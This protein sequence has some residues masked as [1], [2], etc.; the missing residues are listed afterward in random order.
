MSKTCRF[1][2]IT[3]GIAIASLPFYWNKVLAQNSYFQRNLV[4]DIAGMAEKTDTN[5]VNPWGIATGATSPFWV[6][7]NHKGVSTLYDGN[8]VP[9]SLVVT[10][11][12]PSGGTPPAAPTGVVSNS[13][14]NFQ[15]S[16]GLASRF[17]FATEDGTI[18]GWNS[19]ANGVVKVDNSPS[20]AVYKGLGIGATG[21]SNYLYAA[22][23][24]A[25]TI[26]VF[27]QNYGAATLAGSFLDP[28]LPAGFAP[29]NVQNIGGQ[30]YVTYA[31]Q[32]AAKHDDVPGAGNGFVNIFDTSGNL[33]RRLISNGALNSPWG[34]A[35]APT[36]FGPFSGALL[37]GNFGN[38][39]INAF[40]PPTGNLLGT[41]QDPGGNPIT[42]QG[43]WGLIF[44]NGGSGGDTR[45]LYFAAGIAGSATNSIEDHGLFGSISALS[46]TFSAVTDGAITEALN[47]VGGTAPFLLQKKATLSDPAWFN[48][49]TTTNRS[50]TLAKESGTG[51]YRL[52]GA[53]TNTVLPFT[54]Y[55]DGPSEVP[56]TGEAGTGIGA[57]SLEGSNLTY[58]ISFS[59]LTGP[60]TAG[61]IHAPFTP[62]T[63]GG[64]MVPFAVPSATS[65]V[66]SGKVLLTQDQLTNMVNGLC[67]VNIHTAANLGGEIRGQIVPLRMIVTMNGA[68]EVPGVPGNGTAT[69]ALTFV[70]SRLFYTVT[71]SGLSSPGTAMH[72]HGPADPT[73]G[74]GVLVPL[75]TPTGTNGTVSGS[76]TLSPQNLAYLLAGQTYMNIHTVNNGGGEI[77]GQIWPIQFRVNMSGYTEVPITPSA[78]TGSGIM[79]VIS[80][81][82][83]YSFSFTNL[84]GPANAGHIHGPAGPTN[85]AAVLIPFTTVPA[86]TS[87]SF[88]GTATLS[89]LQLYYMISGLTYANI[90][91]TIYGAG[92][93]RG[94]V[95]PHN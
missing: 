74:A 91:S 25:G 76:V 60:A 29:F 45:T 37:V 57:F 38:G 83:S 17:I 84:L 10:I 13:S 78:G 90:H 61:H 8:G 15:V 9:S 42:I 34:L 39:K 85:S 81:K 66:I 14:T 12:P 6:A 1:G 94:Q 41:L 62:V 68:A 53:T 22:N 73:I 47:W 44:G 64:V 56:P 20:G 11:P 86:A 88:T 27:D 82:L 26:D 36:N 52:Q 69:G 43:L 32:D 67:Y 2:R 59:G 46:P 4:S 24:F 80:N 55:L 21:G 19:G 54:A 40:D 3:L 75:T 89:P 65:G 77:R 51:F 63:G 5:L 31:K 79:N 16:P 72:I 23:F 70:G 93:I 92:E 58:Y 7:D 87:G 30:L 18:V 50:M 49:L 28:T 95:V 48:V 71:Y 35:L 33:V